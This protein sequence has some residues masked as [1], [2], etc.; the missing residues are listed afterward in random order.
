[1]RAIKALFM[2]LLGITVSLICVAVWVVSPDGQARLVDPNAASQQSLDTSARSLEQSLQAINHRLTEIHQSPLFSELITLADE[3]PT[4]VDALELRS[5]FEQAYG[6]ASSEQQGLVIL[7]LID[8]RVLLQ[9]SAANQLFT[10]FEKATEHGL[11][12]GPSGETYLTWSLK[13]EEGQV[14]TLLA[15][16]E[17][18]LKLPKGVTLA[19]DESISLE[20]ALLTKSISGPLS[21]QNVVLVAKQPFPLMQ[22]LQ[23]LLVFALACLLLAVLLALRLR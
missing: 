20:Q 7:S 3:D 22:A 17:R 14:V 21:G 12:K 10:D 9:T 19:M 18:N 6:T 8:K 13:A 2:M 16:Q 4:S 15:L 5:Y 1:M 23:V 11:I